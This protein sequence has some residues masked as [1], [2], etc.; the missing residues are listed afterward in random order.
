M[1]KVP[2]PCQSSAASL[3]ELVDAWLFQLRAKKPSART[4]AAYRAD[5]EGV[6]RRIDSDGDGVLHLEDLTKPA[7]RPVRKDRT[8]RAPRT[9]HP[10]A[11]RPRGEVA[12]QLAVGRWTTPER[13]RVTAVPSDDVTCS[14]EDPN[15][16]P[17]SSKASTPVAGLVVLARAPDRHTV[18]GV[19]LT[20]TSA[21]DTDTDTDTD[22]EPPESRHPQ[23]APPALLRRAQS[24]QGRMTIQLPEGA[25][26]G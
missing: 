15:S 16:G 25:A 14:Q 20:R 5:V 26:R 17:P 13:P 7:L 9:S 6:A 11:G 24:R 1:A 10:R 23:A 18:S 19:G 22:T 3:I 21:S 2:R 8:R 4:L 12:A